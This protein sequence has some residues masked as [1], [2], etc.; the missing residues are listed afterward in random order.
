MTT[1]ERSPEER[2]LRLSSKARTEGSGYD[3]TMPITIIRIWSALLAQLEPSSLTS[4]CDSES[5]LYYL[6]ARY[7]DPA[8]AQFVTKD[9]ATSATRS[10]YSYTEGDALNNSDPSG[11]ID[12][13]NLSDSQQQQIEHTCQTWQRQSM[14]TQAAFCAE[15]TFGLGS[16]SG[17]DCHTIAQIAADDYAIVQNALCASHGGDVNLNG[18]VESQAAAQR[19]LAEMKVAFQ[20]ANEGIL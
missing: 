13:S 11:A 16:M 15:H 1:G 3:T 10:P 8:T 14:C 7:Y 17:G 9:P 4:D 6:R 19:D 18:Y 20:V 12:K 2:C 5:G